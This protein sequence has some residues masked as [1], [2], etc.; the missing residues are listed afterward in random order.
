MMHNIIIV[1]FTIIEDVGEICSEDTLD[2]HNVTK[3]FVPQ[4]SPNV[5]GNQG[6]PQEQHP[7]KVCIGSIN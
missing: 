3:S 2:S 5:K 1:F 6:R 4:L 7:P